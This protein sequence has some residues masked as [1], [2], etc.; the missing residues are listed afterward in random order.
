VRA[1]NI[2]TSG[3]E[4]TRIV[5]LSTLEGVSEK[6]I[7]Y[8]HGTGCLVAGNPEAEAGFAAEVARRAGVKEVYCVAYRLLPENC[9]R[10]A[11]TDC[12]EAY[13]YIITIAG[14]V[15]DNVLIIGVSSGA[16]L[17][18]LTLTRLRDMGMSMPAGAAL[19]SPVIGL[20]VMWTPPR[21]FHEWPS[22]QNNKLK[23]A[24]MP[25]T[26]TMW[27]QGQIFSNTDNLMTLRE[28][29][30]SAVGLP[31]LFITTG[32]Y[33]CNLDGVKE[34]AS[35]CDTAGLKVL[36]REYRFMQHSF[37]VYFRLCQ[38]SDSAL[39]DL[40]LW[41]RSTLQ[42]TNIPQRT[43]AISSSTCSCS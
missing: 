38:E 3:K 15:P 23:D 39:R 2:L 1:S 13:K 18:L 32:S 43:P 29:L 30:S 19:I 10:D 5:L 40:V 27:V 34:L 33:E 20:E 24:A 31:P 8:I 42:L 35:K 14:H 17:A 12:V 6:A 25:N 36:F 11:V 28:G 37:Q 22:C 26:F 9:L 4:S 21:P 41:S 7:L 16:M